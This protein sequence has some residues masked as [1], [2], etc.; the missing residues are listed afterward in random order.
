MNGRMAQMKIALLI[1]FVLSGILFMGLGW[2]L[3]QR[4]VPPN[5]LYGF[6]VKKTLQNPDHWY[7]ANAHFGVRLFWVGLITVLIC[8]GGYYVPGLTPVIY[9]VACA[10]FVMIALAVIVFQT[11]SYLNQLD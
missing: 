7:Q 11:F 1:I 3:K 9:G 4:K 2:P 6:R 8:L 5:T 10:V